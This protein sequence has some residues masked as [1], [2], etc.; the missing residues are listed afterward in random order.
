MHFV[1]G[2]V[3]Y[4]LIVIL[5]KISWRFLCFPFGLM[6]VVRVCVV[7]GRGGRFIYL[8]F[9]TLLDSCNIIYIDINR[10]KRSQSTSLNLSISQS[11]Y[12]SI[13]LV[14]IMYPE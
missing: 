4:T 12:P 2:Q 9:L 5:C 1:L 6:V 11:F 7:S 8:C 3:R 10:I 13:H 14:Y